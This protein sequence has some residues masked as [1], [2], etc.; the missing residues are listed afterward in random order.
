VGIL[1]SVLFSVWAVLSGEPLVGEK[2][3]IDLNQICNNLFNTTAFGTLEGQ[4]SLNFPH[5]HYMIGVY[6]H[7]VLFAVGYIASF[8][9]KQDKNIA[10]LT[11]YDW[12][13]THKKV[14]KAAAQM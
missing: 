9:F 14:A 6:S 2:S 12:R 4:T 10:G 5:H 8:F 13:K 1:A 11:F 7:I 3:L